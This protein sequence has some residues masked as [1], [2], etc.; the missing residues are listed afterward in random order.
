MIIDPLENQNKQIIDPLDNPITKQSG[1]G[2]FGNDVSISQGEEPSFTDNTFTDNTFDR[3]LSVFKDPKK[4]RAK[5]FVALVNADNLTRDIQK[6]DPNALPISPSFAYKY[7]D[8]INKHYSIDPE[9]KARIEENI[10]RIQQFNDT[11]VQDSYLDT[12]WKS[13]KRFPVSM[14]VAAGGIIQ[15]MEEDALP[16]MALRIA[17]KFGNK[18]AEN[19]YNIALDSVEKKKVFSYGRDVLI[20]EAKRKLAGMEHNV[21][22]DSFQ[23]TVGSATESILNNM[24]F[25]IPGFAYGRALPLAA[26]GLQ[27]AGQTY[28]SQR[29]GGMKPDTA[30]TAAFI[31]GLAEAGTEF[32]P[33]G[34][35]LKPNAGIVKRIIEA[36][37]TEVPTEV[38]NTMVN[39]IVDKVTLRPDMTIEDAIYDINKTIQ[40]TALS[41]VGMAGFSHS[42]NKALAK[43]LPPDHK[44]IFGQTS[45][46]V[47]DNGGTAKEAAKKGIEAV[48]KT[49]G[50]K[51]YI[52]Q[53]IDKMKQEAM[54]TKQNTEPFIIGV[55]DESG[56]VQSFTMADPVSGETFEVPAINTTKDNEGNVTKLIPD[57]KAVN[58]ELLKIREHDDIDTK[59][60]NIIQGDED[61]DKI[62]NQVF[63]EE[64][65]PAP[66]GAELT[67]AETESGADSKVGVGIAQPDSL[68][69]EARKYKTAEEFIESQLYYHGTNKTFKEFK[70]TTNAEL[71]RGYYF[72]PDMFA[73]QKF[74]WGKKVGQGGK[75]NIITVTPTFKNPLILGE[76]VDGKLALELWEKSSA[77]KP[78]GGAIEKIA[79]DG[80]YDAI[81]RKGY[82]EGEEIMVF[83]KKNIK[84]HSQSATPEEVLHKTAETKSQLTDIWNKAHGEIITPPEN[85]KAGVGI[86]QKALK[87]LQNDDG[88]MVLKDNEGK[89]LAIVHNLSV[90]NLRHAIKMGGLP[91]PSTGVINVKKTKYDSFGEITLIAS[92]ERL[93]PGGSQKYFNA[94][95]YSP[96][97]PRV[98]YFLTEK[99]RKSL[100]NWLKP[101]WDEIP[102]AKNEQ[103]GIS[104][105]YTFIEEIKENGVD[106]AFEHGDELLYYAFLKESG[107]LPDGVDRSWEGKTKL[108]ETVEAIGKDEYNQW[109]ERKIKELGLEADEKIF[110]G[111]TYQGNRKYLKHDLDTVVI[112]LKKELKDGEGFNYGVPSVRAKAA[113]QYK[114][115]KQIKDDRNKIVSSEEMEALKTQTNDEFMELAKQV[116]PH[117]KYNENTFVTLDR[118]SEHLKEAIETHNFYKVFGENS[119]YYNSGVDIK[120]IINYVNKLHNMPTEYF[121]GKIQRA[122]GLTEFDRAVV[123]DNTPDDIIQW[124][125]SHGI[126]VDKYI[127]DDI[128]N[129]RMTVEKAA[130]EGNAS[131]TLLF[132]GLD[133]TQTLD[134]LRGLT[135]NIK[136]A[137]PRLA[138]LGRQVYQNG[139]VQFDE[140]SAKMKEHLGDMWESFKFHMEEVFETVKKKLSEERG[141]FS[142]KDIE[143]PVHDAIAYIKENGGL[144]IDKLSKQYPKETIDAL[145]KKGVAKKEG[146]L[147]LDVVA[148]EFQMD[149]DELLNQILEVKSKKALSDSV[150]SKREDEY[151]KEAY[152][153]SPVAREEFKAQLSELRQINNQLKGKIY[154]SELNNEQLKERYT[155]L[156]NNIKWMA[157]RK[158]T[159]KTVRDYFGLTDNDMRKISRKNPLL[160]DKAEFKEYLEDVQLQS[161]ILN[162]TRWAKIMLMKLIEDKR[163]QKVDNYRRVLQLPSIDKMTFDQLREFAKLLEPF[164]EDDMFLTQ[165][166]LETVD[167]TDLKGIKTW[168]EAREKLAKETGVSVE[169]LMNVKVGQLDSF[170]WDTALREQDPFFDLL[171]TK[172]TESIMGA[173]MQSHNVEST[174]YDLAKKAKKSRSRGIVER[175][176]PQDELVF[177]FLEAPQEEKDAIAQ[178]MTPDEINLAHFIKQYFANALNYLISIKA[179]E[180]GREN[181][182]THIRKS[183]LE[184]MRD[185][186][187]K[188]AIGG[189]FTTYQED[190]IGFNILD[191][192]T[193]KILPLEKFFQFSLHR[194]GEVDPTKNVVR[195]FMTY[196]AMFERKKA[197]DAIIPKLD[198]YTQSLTPTRMTPR[199]L[200]FDRSLKTFV[201]KYINNKK[202]RKI[203]YD[204]VV[205]Q[206]GPLD[207][208]IRALRTFTAI[209]DL[210]FY[211]PAQIINFGGEQLT[212]MVPLGVKDY[213]KS[214]ALMRTEK[215]KRILKK[216]E[217]F[218][219]RS[220]WEEFTAPGKVVTERFMAGMFGF[221]H[222]STV[223]ANKQFLLAS[224]TDEE[225]KNEEL[226]PERLAILKLEMG[227][228]RAIPG[229]N[230]LVGSTSV[231]NSAMQYKAWAVPPTR[232]LIKDAMTM[233]D[234]LAKKKYGE[235]LTSKEAREIYRIVGTSISLVMLISMA[236]ADDEDDDNTF[237]SK[238]K[239][240][241]EREL[242]TLTQGMNPVF[243]LSWRTG[244]FLKQLAT[245]LTNI[246]TLEEYKT[247]EGYKG[248]GQLKK[249]LTPGAIRNLPKKE[250]EEE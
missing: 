75:Q 125:N 131:G 53:K 41:T 173:E 222:I 192:S 206:G 165:R 47:I 49:E 36:E 156:R 195:A 180:Y 78:N 144:N 43:M 191:D 8:A 27:S 249:T 232:T 127:K 110:D 210:G 2:L 187:I 220:L 132:S 55:N 123:P 99:S 32:I 87:I 209:V 124:L 24:A 244:S 34:I 231:G 171:V 81:I 243:W 226:S 228:F 1:S 104:S 100:D 38:V 23:E 211:V 96:R 240:R 72:T 167:R 88:S 105:P 179:V 61:V 126:K 9:S 15:A 58:A 5:A 111:F 114:S 45:K 73:A 89:D 103:G 248:V 102:K 218:T 225:Y 169:E 216:Y 130:T 212:T 80:G 189:I 52:D 12:F 175:A 208:G 188:E 207:L 238:M 146:S 48:Q 233:A 62:V 66:S 224:M 93:G 147:Q 241:A 101:L 31:N 170:K 29:Q 221:L 177:N 30:L 223:A 117:L 26:M 69:E 37:F 203:S 242:F 60:D 141:S 150:S 214:I 33:M 213:A 108:R 201:N 154:F 68:L 250:E 40:V 22:P 63:G 82:G 190:M 20:P 172:M 51:A 215:G 35:Y 174:L 92:K 119:E 106:V 204:S 227:R 198:I 115:I 86:A 176:I 57:A 3:L 196:V 134:V 107:M 155:K 193:G 11:G 109:S 74:A 121:E 19:L 185:K 148:N 183:F 42:V 4:E 65:L 21:M 140:W 54:Q 71:G 97:Y 239:K 137:M 161:V 6:R 145:K 246:V 70:H 7:S 116:I 182:I 153:N 50:G 166:E 79:K 163:L 76:G 46:E 135:N 202:G 139:K 199:G 235:A 143:S 160:M 95:I 217:F 91:V 64:Q 67:G 237:L 168:R 164:E 39:D 112:L 77:Q 178:Q 90:N 247:K 16:M 18:E 236:G 205:R 133:I 10:K 59:L 118:F 98:T 234:N 83:D 142:N 159:L 128:E 13:I 181:Y 14:Q 229:T 200:E 149:D 122:V 158:E 85:N 84:I 44:K 56:E 230:S 94:D 129:R 186:G 25:L 120:A 162:D 197:F 138:E 17:G 152:Y 219:E 194:T 157:K 151:L 184:N 28:A 113:K 136:E 245:A